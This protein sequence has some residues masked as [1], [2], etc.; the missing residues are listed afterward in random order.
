[1]A[2]LGGLEEAAYAKT[3]SR[4][5]WALAGLGGLHEAQL[6]PDVKRTLLALVDWTRP[7]IEKLFQAQLG[8]LDKATH[9]TRLHTKAFTGSI[10][11]I[12]ERF[13]SQLDLG[14]KRTWL[15]LVEWTRPFRRSFGC[16]T[17]LASLGGLHEDA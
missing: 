17:D 5:I 6:D 15:A 10:T 7:R 14:V 4:P 9:T 12:E 8:G 16:Q 3:F 1:M 2:G 13:Q 11:C